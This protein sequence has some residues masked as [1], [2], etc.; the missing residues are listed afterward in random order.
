LISTDTHKKYIDEF[1]AIV[2]NS[3]ADLDALIKSVLNPKAVLGNR[4]LLKKS[5]RIAMTKKMAKYSVQTGQ[6]GRRLF[7]EKLNVA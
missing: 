1:D 4:I 6:L 2:E 7:K 5:F 3:K